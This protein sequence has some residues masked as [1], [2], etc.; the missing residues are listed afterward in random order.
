MTVFKCKMCGGELDITENATIAICEFCGRKQT[1][2]RLNDEKIARLYDRAGHFRRNNE[3]DKAAAI[4]EDILNENT[5]DAEAYWSLV[6]CKYGIEYVEDPATQNRIPTVNRAQFTSVFD[7]DNYRSALKYADIEQK[8]IYEVEAK[9]I[10]EIQRGILAISQKEEPFDIFICYK[11]SDKFGSR[12]RDSV[13]AQEIYYQLTNE[14]YKV[15][16]SRVTLED[17]LGVAYEPYIFAALNSAKIMIVVGSKQEYFNAVWVKNEW[18]RY[19]SLVKQSDGKKMLIPA[20]K[21]MD[22]YDLPDEFSHLQAQ[23]M[24]KLGFMQDLIRGIKKIIPQKSA[25]SKIEATATESSH[26]AS[27]TPKNADIENILKR[28]FMFLEDRDFEKADEYA[29]KALDQNPESSDAYLVKF[30]VNNK[31]CNLEDLANNP[32]YFCNDQYYKMLLKYGNDKIKAD[33]RRIAD[34]YVELLGK[35]SCVYSYGGASLISI[36]SICLDTDVQDLPTVVNNILITDK[37]NITKDDDGDL[38]CEEIGDDGN[39]WFRHIDSDEKYENITKDNVKIIALKSCNGLNTIRILNGT[40]CIPSKAFME[41]HSL[42]NIEIPDSV[43]SIEN[44]AFTSCSS[45]GELKLP[46]NIKVL[47]EKVFCGCTALTN[48]EI[49]SSV[50]TIGYAAFKGC[51]SLQRLNLQNVT[52]LGNNALENCGALRHLTL[53]SELKY[54]SNS[55]IF[56]GHTSVKYIA[57]SNGASTINKSLLEQFRYV[58]EEIVLPDSITTLDEALF[59]NYQNL[60]AIQLSNAITVIPKDAFK[61]CKSLEKIV[62][63]DSVVSIEWAAFKDCTSLK[64]IT[65][66]PNLES[67]FP[68]TFE[69]CTSLK[70]FSANKYFGN[71]KNWPSIIRY[72]VNFNQVSDIEDYAFKDCDLIKNL[73]IPSGITSIG[74]YAFSN[75]RNLESITIPNTVTSIGDHAFYYCS[76]LKSMSLPTSVTNIGESAFESCTSLE[77]IVIPN[78]VC[79]IKENTF[80]GCNSLKKVTIPTTVTSIG[81]Y[82]FN[83]CSSLSEIDI[84]D[85]AISLGTGAF[86]FCESLSQVTLPN[87]LETISSDLFSI[88]DSLQKINIPESVTVIGEDAFSGCSSLESITLPN[89][90]KTIENKA[91]SGCT[92]LSEIVIPEGVT[93]IGFFA[94]EGCTSLTEIVIPESVVSMGD[95]IFENCS[96]DLHVIKKGAKSKKGCYVATAV[97]GSY[98]CPQVWTLRRYRDYT[99]SKTWYGRA[100]IH[101]YYAVSPKLVKWFGKTN[102]FKRI[103]QGKLDRMIKKLNDSGV[104]N[105]PY[106]DRKWK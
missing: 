46:N 105:T 47:P 32:V 58:A 24:S 56:G 35:V 43:T 15:F 85:S 10:N 34:S 86:S 3:F 61:N 55:N 36:E 94:F 74:N 42:K 52:L 1:L 73:V 17:K 30:L 95:G 11:E 59:A 38:L 67:I 72:D 69:G 87:G 104:E 75:C 103:C 48:L 100:F 90:L 20:Y 27:Q 44:N 83:F 80:D 78:G 65:I 84:P 9:A 70:Y 91:F 41:S 99:L 23:D 64:T 26:P 4:Y 33:L 19:L 92:S 53:S 89:I 29:E 54:Q 60:K 76:N 63:P 22:P 50:T 62:I 106:D 66:P 79:H 81:D 5:E 2:P 37:Y 71:V 102:W 97:Y 77:E 16:F 21:D 7:D 101:L 14:G 31:R 98:D 57:F 39:I 6:L 12:T 88:C 13:V 25:A 40:N 93:S 28:A 49:P 51:S 68:D 82:A 8:A 18:S 96:I 45:L